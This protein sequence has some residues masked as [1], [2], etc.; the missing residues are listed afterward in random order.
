MIGRN[1]TESKTSAG[2]ADAASTR[3]DRLVAQARAAALWEQAWPV[4]WRGIGVGL[5]FLVVSWAGVWLD[6]TPLWRQIG[7]GALGAL[8][9]AALLPLIHV[10]RPDRRLALARLDREAASRDPKLRHGPASAAED[11]LA[12][13]AA[14]PGAGCCGISTS[15]GPRR[16][17]RPCGSAC[18][19]RA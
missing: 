1:G 19:G 6:L 5:L 15:A 13:G 11:S 16:R 10:G 7:L 9:V 3:L 8:L 2:G 12:V 17:S 18:R 14:D 4:L